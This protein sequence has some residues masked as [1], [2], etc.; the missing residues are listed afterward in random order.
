M[1]ADGRQLGSTNPVLVAHLEC[2]SVKGRRAFGYHQG[3][4]SDQ[5]APKAGYTIAS[6]PSVGT[7][8]SLQS[9][10]QWCGPRP[11][12]GVESRT[13]TAM[14]ED[15]MQ[16]VQIGLDLAKYVFEVHG[17]ARP[18]SE[19]RGSALGSEVGRFA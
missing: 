6:D 4:R 16:V 1:M 5:A 17:V 2:D 9:R 15:I 12:G 8:M 3:Q 19:Q 11:R 10:G 13:S 14:K 18:A 7:S